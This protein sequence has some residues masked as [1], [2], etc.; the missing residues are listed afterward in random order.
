[1]SKVTSITGKNELLL[2]A[3]LMEAV[4]RQMQNQRDTANTIID[5]AWKE[6]DD[7]PVFTDGQRKR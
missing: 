2:I 6:Y 3:R 4:I 1:M 5:M 7:G